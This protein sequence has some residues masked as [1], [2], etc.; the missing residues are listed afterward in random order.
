MSAPFVCPL[1][2]A[3]SQNPND[4]ANRYCGRCHVFADDAAEADVL[5]DATAKKRGLRGLEDITSEPNEG[6]PDG[7]GY[8]AWVT[9]DDRVEDE[10][11]KE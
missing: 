9:G 5:L 2:G 4:A 10:G 8:G 7:Y 6:A 11:G 3:V 1:C